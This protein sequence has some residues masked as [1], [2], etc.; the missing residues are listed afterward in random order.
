MSFSLRIIFLLSL[1]SVPL[2]A[3]TVIITSVSD[4]VRGPKPLTS[5]AGIP[6]AEGTQVLVG[7]FP[8]LSDD[9]IQDGAAQG[10]LAQV[11]AAFVRFGAV[12]AIGQGVDGAAGG[13]EIA[14]KD[15]TPA[16]WVGEPISLLILAANG[17]F[18]VARFEG[19]KFK[20]ETV[21]GLEPLLSL[22]LADAKVLVGNRLGREKLATAAA[23]LIGS[24][25]TWVTGY[26][27]IIDPALRLPA[28]D[29]DSDG[30]SNLLEYATG[31]NPASGAD[32]LPS[33]ILPDGQ[34]GLWIRFRYVPGLGPIRYRVESSG[35]P[36]DPWLETDGTL[37]SDPE[38]PATLRLHLTP[39][40]DPT[41][42][43]RLQ[44]IKTP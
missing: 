42:F 24:F 44:V 14:V 25:N 15:K 40:L 13:F 2:P 6:L 4:E 7:A 16:P 32:P 11:T 23:P 22:H 27:A 19:T 33:E 3:G 37:E 39:P 29:A 20:A 26:S 38:N 17:E 43:F 18:L 35:T 5:L 28:A 36:A 41:R 12:C 1:I 9:G 8:G 31:G 30:R 21:T 10:G 34:G